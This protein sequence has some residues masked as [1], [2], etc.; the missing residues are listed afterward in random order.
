MKVLT[1]KKPLLK[2]LLVLATEIQLKINIRLTLKHKRI[3]IQ[4]KK[5]NKKLN[6]EKKQ[7]YN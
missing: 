5:G 3:K 7:I 2:M 6:I 1:H 4:L